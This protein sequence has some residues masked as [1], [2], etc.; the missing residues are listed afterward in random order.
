TCRRPAARTAA[1]SRRTPPP[2]PAPPPLQVA[3]EDRL[4]LRHGLDLKEPLAQPRS[5][6]HP[7]RVPAEVFPE[8]QRGLAGVALDPQREARV[9]QG[10]REPLLGLR[11]GALGPPGEKILGLREQPRIPERSARDHD[12]GAGG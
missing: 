12:P 1:P 2:A 10:R 9:L 3:A 7:P 11:I 5:A 4:R 8:L 6:R